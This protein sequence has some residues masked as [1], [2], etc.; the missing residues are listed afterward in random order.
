M[1]HSPVKKTLSWLSS[2][3]LAVI[4]REI[5]AKCRRK[6]HYFD[7]KCNYFGSGI[8]FF[9][10]QFDFTIPIGIAI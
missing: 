9:F 5:E 2:L 3:F 1:Y 7:Q 4:Q 6:S 10:I 8:A